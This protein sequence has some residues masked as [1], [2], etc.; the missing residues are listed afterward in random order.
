VAT[1]GCSVVVL[2][3]NG[4]SVASD[5]IFAGKGPIAGWSSAWACALPAIPLFPGL[6]LAPGLTV[7]TRA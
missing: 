2:P 5:S 6:D 4:G 3:S 1:S 7:G